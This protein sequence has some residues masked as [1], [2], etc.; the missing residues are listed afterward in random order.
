MVMMFLIKVIKNITCEKK[1][2]KKELF[3]ISDTAFQVRGSNSNMVRWV[4]GNSQMKR[5]LSAKARE[6]SKHVKPKLL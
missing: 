5:Y 2:K 6:N 3:Q 1:R 4:L